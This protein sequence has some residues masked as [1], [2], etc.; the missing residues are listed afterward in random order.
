MSTKKTTTMVVISPKNNKKKNKTRSKGRN[1]SSQILGRQ[2]TEII[3][4]VPISKTRITGNSNTFKSF[5]LP[6]RREMLKTISLNQNFG[7]SELCT[8]NPGSISFSSWLTNIAN[9]F[10][11]YKFHSLKFIYVPRCA[12]TLGGSIYMVPDTNPKDPMPATA[13]QASQNERTKSASPWCEFEISLT[14][15]MLSKRKSYFCRKFD[16]IP[17]GGDVDLYDTGNLFLLSEGPVATASVGQLW[18]EYDIEFFTPEYSQD[19]TPQ[20]NF[21][22]NSSGMSNVSP[23]LGNAA[24]LVQEEVGESIFSITNDGTQ[25]IL[26]FN[27]D[28]HGILNMKM[29]GVGLTQPNISALSAG[30]VNVIENGFNI[31]NSLVNSTATFNSLSSLIDMKYGGSLGLKLPSATSVASSILTLTKCFL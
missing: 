3:R 22:R 10:E 27:R 23:I 2:Q 14:K 7:I 16:V 6:R 5:R 8:I 25:D 24:T 9:C 29:N 30:T 21:A 4:S 13:V 11:S 15:E 19:T 26:T 31:A 18:V 17:P 20:T 28:F 12:T 1:A